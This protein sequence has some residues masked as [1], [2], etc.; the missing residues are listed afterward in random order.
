MAR[1]GQKKEG[2][3][4]LLSFLPFP[5]AFLRFGTVP[6]NDYWGVIYV[7]IAIILAPLSLLAIKRQMKK[8]TD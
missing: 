7:P 5:I 1:N 2:L 6:Y 4:W 8:P 3:F